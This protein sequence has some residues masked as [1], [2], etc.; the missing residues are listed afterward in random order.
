MLM[1]LT[2][3]ISISLLVVI[4]LKLNNNHKID[5]SLLFFIL[6]N[7]LLNFSTSLFLFYYTNYEIALIS[8]ILLVIFSLLLLFDFKRVLKYM[9]LISLPYL[10]Y[11]VYLTFYIVF[12]II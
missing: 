4:I 2:F 7:Y 10:F 8:S 5:N 12:K 1:Y 11:N 3:L 9:P 6:S